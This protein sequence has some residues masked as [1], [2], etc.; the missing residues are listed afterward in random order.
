MCPSYFCNER[1]FS[2]IFWNLYIKVF[3]AKDYTAY[4]SI[5][6]SITFPGAFFLSRIKSFFCR[7]HRHE[8][9]LKSWVWLTAIVTS[10]VLFTLQ[11]HFFIF[12]ALLTRETLPPTQCFDKP[13]SVKKTRIN[14][15]VLFVSF[16]FLFKLFIHVV[17]V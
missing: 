14:T 6:I 1:L 12:Y 17:L 4:R 10:S 7:Q 5:L 11:F 3:I 8:K 16:K 9:T 15:H 2:T 13:R